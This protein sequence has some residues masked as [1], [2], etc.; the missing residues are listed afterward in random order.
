MDANLLN[1]LFN[2]TSL[3]CLLLERINKLTNMKSGDWKIHSQESNTLQVCNL[4]R[5]LTERHIQKRAFPM[6]FFRFFA[7]VAK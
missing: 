2:R 5:F 3:G 4:N 7:V 1:A 6:Y